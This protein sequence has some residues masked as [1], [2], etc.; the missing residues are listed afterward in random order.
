[1]NK[2]HLYS[3]T[4]PVYIFDKMIAPDWPCQTYAVSEGRAKANFEYQIKMNQI[5]FKLRY[6]KYFL[7][8]YK[9]ISRFGDSPLVLYN[10]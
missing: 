2:K 7:L 10:I 4:G 5:N 6:I 9:Y 3:Y 1:M 8:K